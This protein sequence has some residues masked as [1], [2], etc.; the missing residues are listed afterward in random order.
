[1][2]SSV[3]HLTND[4]VLLPV[5]SQRSAS[6]F[7]TTSNSESKDGLRS[8]YLSLT[9]PLTASSIS[10]AVQFL[11]QHE[12]STSGQTLATADDEERSIYEAT[13]GKLA[14]GIYAQALDT[15]LNEAGSAESEAEWWADV[16]RSQLNAAYYLLQTLPKRMFDLV[17]EVQLALRRQ[18]RE[19]NVSMLRPSHLNRVLYTDD[20]PHN[21]IL[22]TLFP[23][24]HTHPYIMPFSLFRLHTPLPTPAILSLAESKSAAS[25]LVHAFTHFFKSI[26]FFLTLPLELTRQECAVKRKELEALRDSRAEVL[27]TLTLRRDYLATALRSGEIKGAKLHSFVE[28]VNQLVAGEKYGRS[29]KDIAPSQL[30]ATALNETLPAHVALHRSQ[31]Q[32]G[33][34]RPGRWTLRWPRLVLGPPL[35]LLGIR[36]AFASRETLATV[37]HDA[38][39]TLH[40][41]YHGW[42]LDPSKDILHTVRSGGEEGVIVQKESID[43]DLQSL[44]R[45]ALDLARDKLGY[46]QEQLATLADKVRRGDL[47]PILEIYEADIKSPVRSAVSGT[48]LRNLFIQVQKAKVDIDQA[49]AGI[50]K[51]LKSQELTFAFVGVA[52]ALAL[53]YVAGG[54][55]RAAWRGGAGAGRHG[56]RRQRAKAWLAIRRTERL[57]VSKPTSDDHIASKDASIP[58][59]TAGLLLLSVSS[60]RSYAERCLPARSRLQTGFLEDVEDLE[61]PSLDRDEKWKVVERMWRNWGD[62]LG[63][64]RGA[65][66]IATL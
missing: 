55:L 41:F 66:T 52:P 16:E 14:A 2:S 57:L 46:G 42:L 38:V 17:N 53:V 37:A 51:L 22:T 32:G 13:V 56:G 33:L 58:P 60:L 15:F 23:H 21:A 39:E 4:L 64:R 50:D 9:P 7:T 36:Q 29:P 30:L 3:S 25:S 35:L 27:G 6:S 10:D 62:V 48:L 40:R 63:W 11:Q 59:L 49:L 45:M 31:M 61:N 8:L 34:T 43:A 18:S 54:G 5:P 24:L 20:R 26:P 47:T 65:G 44:S 28:S 19:F 12:F 1:M